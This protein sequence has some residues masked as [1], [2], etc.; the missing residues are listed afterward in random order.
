M[1]WYQDFGRKHPHA[2]QVFLLSLP[3]R[4]LDVIS[5]GYLAV[6]LDFFF[7]FFHKIMGFFW[8]C[9][10]YHFHFFFWYNCQALVHTVTGT[11][12]VSNIWKMLSKIP[13]LILIQSSNNSTWTCWLLKGETIRVF[14][15]LFWL[16]CAMF[17]ISVNQSQLALFVTKLKNPISNQMKKNPIPTIFWRTLANEL[18]TFTWYFISI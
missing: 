1:L 4:S 10:Q 17:N 3:L 16:K 12:S 9:C 11:F 2:Q 6:F 15:V 8:Q 13:Q 7:F 14:M 5:Q 18:I